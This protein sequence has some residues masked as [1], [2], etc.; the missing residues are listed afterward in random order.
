MSKYFCMCGNKNDKRIIQ[1]RKKIGACLTKL[2]GSM[3]QW[4]SLSASVRCIF[5]L[6]RCNARAFL[7]VYIKASESIN[8]SNSVG[9]AITARTHHCKSKEGHSKT[10]KFHTYNAFVQQASQSTEPTNLCIHNLATVFK[11]VASNKVWSK[12]PRH[13]MVLPV[14][15]INTI[16]QTGTSK[17]KR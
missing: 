1:D 10:R 17:A 5:F 12:R 7:L 8:H 15:Q 14:F 11:K 3:F 6:S 9:G 4:I 16:W 13:K 2:I